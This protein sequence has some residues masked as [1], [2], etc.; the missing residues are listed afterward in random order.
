MRTLVIRMTMPVAEPA[1][2]GY[3]E[4][5]FRDLVEPSLRPFG[6]AR[7]VTVEAPTAEEEAELTRLDR[8]A[9]TA[10]V[11]VE[12]D[13]YQRHGED[14]ADLAAR[15][16][17]R[18]AG[19]EATHRELEALT[20]AATATAFE[21][22]AQRH[23]GGGPSRAQVEEAMRRAFMGTDA[24]TP[25]ERIDRAYVGAAPGLAVNPTYAK[26]LGTDEGS[27]RHISDDI[28]DAEL[29]YG[30]RK[31]LEQGHTLMNDV[32]E[33]GRAAEARQ[34]QMLQIRTAIE[35]AVRELRGWEPGATDRVADG[36]Q[37]LL[38]GNAALTGGVAA[39]TPEE[40]RT[41]H[42]VWAGDA[43]DA[44]Y[45]ESVQPK[46]EAIAGESWR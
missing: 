32:I 40:A 33:N 41:L 46:L 14:A 21:L 24:D 6:D 2:V 45:L 5:L 26:A 30:L 43:F 36:L 18:R 16:A 9:G 42:A 39:I 12:P 37:E 17:V 4:S 11:E 38:D 22:L 35:M 13:G 10:P 1:P 8:R 28:P 20:L 29:L 7:L 3:S 31:R 23:V 15:T 27:T 34:Q 19:I 25:L 44:M